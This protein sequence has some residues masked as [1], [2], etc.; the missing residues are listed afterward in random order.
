MIFLK[1]SSP[2]GGEMQN[3]FQTIDIFVRGFASRDAAMNFASRH[4]DT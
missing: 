4:G 1:Q 3:Q 2:L